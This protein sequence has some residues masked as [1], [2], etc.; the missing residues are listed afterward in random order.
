MLCST[1]SH[2]GHFIALAPCRW[3]L[4]L[5]L[6]SR[7]SSTGAF[8][9]SVMYVRLVVFTSLYPF[10]DSRTGVMCH[11][12]RLRAATAV[13]D[14][15]R[16]KDHK[17]PVSPLTPRLTAMSSQP[18]I[19]TSF[20]THAVASTLWLHAM[21]AEREEVAVR[22]VSGVQ[23]FTRSRLGPED[24]GTVIFLSINHV[25]AFNNVVSAAS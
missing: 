8:S 25:S 10:N 17:T 22:G 16:A 12:R 15:G 5:I 21:I 18:S 23:L 19:G 20:N 14:L 7:P 13:A 2:H 9:L 4:A 6:H 1:A 24:T 3:F 11:S